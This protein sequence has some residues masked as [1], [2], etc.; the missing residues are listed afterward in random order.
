MNVRQSEVWTAINNA[1][2][3]MGEAKVGLSTFKKMWKQE[4]TN[5]HVPTESRFSKC[6][7]CWEYKGSIK[8]MPNE[9]T[10]HAIQQSYN[11]HIDLTMEEKKII[12]EHDKQQL[13]ALMTL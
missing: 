6:Q 7:I 9:R 4:Y 5:V 10:K 8:A 11:L 13:K 2:E 12:V 1:L 3:R